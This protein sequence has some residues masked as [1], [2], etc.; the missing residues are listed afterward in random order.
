M[1]DR[2]LRDAVLASARHLL[3]GQG[4]AA[5]AAA[6][7]LLGFPEEA[8]RTLTASGLDLART[9]RPGAVLLAAARHWELTR[10]TAVAIA[11][12]D[13]VG[14]LVPALRRA[15]DGDDRALGVRALPGVA[16][17]LEAAGQPRAADDAAPGGNVPRRTRQH[18]RIG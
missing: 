17:L 7:D 14:A 3:L 10:D 16:S 4:T 18:R 8:A 6:L 5:V 12:V 15:S 13:L 11:V 9:D 2:R 1:P